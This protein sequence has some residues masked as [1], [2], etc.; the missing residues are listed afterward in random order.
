MGICGGHT[1]NSLL[2]TTSYNRP[3]PV[4]DHFVNNNYCFLN[5]TK[6]QKLPRK[7]PLVKFHK[8]PQPPFKPKI[9]HILLFS[10]YGK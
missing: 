7:Q 5:Q 9:W 10:V 2:A 6:F 4:S 8:Q 1:V 3:P